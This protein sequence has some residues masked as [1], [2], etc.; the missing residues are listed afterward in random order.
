VIKPAARK[1]ELG[2][3]G[4]ADRETMLRLICGCRDKAASAAMLQLLIRIEALESR[5]SRKKARGR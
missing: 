2:L 4:L 5:Q 3:E 1:R